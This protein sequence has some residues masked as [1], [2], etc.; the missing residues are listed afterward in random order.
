MLGGKWATASFH[1]KW[2]NFTFF[3][4]VH[5]DSDIDLSLKTQFGQPNIFLDLS[6]VLNFSMEILVS[7]FTS[8]VFENF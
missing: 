3:V 1:F 2:H 6:H 7:Y 4:Y 8:F 5:L